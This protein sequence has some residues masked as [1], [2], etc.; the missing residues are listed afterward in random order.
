LLSVVVLILIAVFY[1]ALVTNRHAYKIAL[2][3]LIGGIIGNLIDRIKL[4]WVIDFLDFYLFDLHWPAFNVADSS[5]CIGVAIY[6]ISSI[7]FSAGFSRLFSR[8]D[9]IV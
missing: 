1:R 4:G 3:C 6:L 8:P 2:G 5:I 7:Y 9:R